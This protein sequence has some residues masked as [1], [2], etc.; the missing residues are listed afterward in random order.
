MSTSLHAL[1]QLSSVLGA[2]LLVEEGDDVA[3]TAARIAQERGIT[4]ILLGA[5]R[6]A[7]GLGRLRE[8]LPMRLVR[9]A[10]GVDVR[11]VADRTRMRGRRGPR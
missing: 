10:P 9:M 3:T 1:R 8:P 6:P 7:R 5:S 11:I 2:T 4:Y